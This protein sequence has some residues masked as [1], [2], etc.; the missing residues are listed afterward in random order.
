MADVVID[1][2]PRR[3]IHHATEQGSTFVLGRTK[4]LPELPIEYRTVVQDARQ[5]SRPV[6]PYPKEPPPDQRPT[7]AN[8]FHGEDRDSGNARSRAGVHSPVARSRGLVAQLATFLGVL[9]VRLQIHTSLA[10][11]R[12]HFRSGLPQVRQLLR[13]CLRL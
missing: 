7:D 12:A 11:R 5:K 10:V 9:Y 3:V 2:Q 8:E 6:Q 1:G 4:G 13:R